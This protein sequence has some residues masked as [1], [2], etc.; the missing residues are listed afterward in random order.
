MLLHP[1]VH[2]PDPVSRAAQFVQAAGGVGE[3]FAIE[4]HDG[5]QAAPVVF[6]FRHRTAREFFPDLAVQQVPVRA[7]PPV[8]ALFDIAHDQALAPIV[9]T[10]VQ[11]RAEIGPLDA[12]GI[13][14]FV[15]EEMLEPNPQFLI[16]KG[17][18]L[19]V[20]DLQQQGIGVVQ[21]Q[22]VLFF[23]QGLECAV[24]FSRDAQ[25]VQLAP[26]QPGC[27]ID[28]VGLPEQV[29]EGQQRPFQPP[30]D[31]SQQFRILLGEPFRRIAT[32]P[33]KGLGRRCY[34]PFPVCQAGIVLD[35]TQPAPGSLFR[36][37]PTVFQDIQDRLCLVLHPVPEVFLHLFED[38]LDT[39]QVFRRVESF[40]VDA[41]R[42]NLLAESIALQLLGHFVQSLLQAEGALLV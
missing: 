24:Q 14:E 38:S 40:L 30:F 4:I 15:Q 6:H 29:A 3:E 26:Q 31:P 11:Q 21:A 16:D 37:H 32:G 1:G 22:D 12:R 35:L 34:L 2:V 41:R 17:R 39:L 28:L 7:P 5:F 27:P 20:Y 23:E 8:N 25:L 10:L 18:I 33:D 42:L 13:L 36:I 19:P 9:V